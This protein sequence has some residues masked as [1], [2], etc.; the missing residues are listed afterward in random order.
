VKKDIPELRSMRPEP[1]RDFKTGKYLLPHP[2]EPGVVGAWDRATT[3]AGLHEDHAPLEKWQLRQALDG[4]TRD[5][6]ILTEVRGL[7][8]QAEA[9]DNWRDANA[10]KKK[11]DA[12]AVRA[13]DTAGSYDGSTWGTLLHT[14]TEW[15]DA[16]RLD[17]VL[18]EITSWG[19]KGE[20]LLRDLDVYTKTMAE[21][22]L[23]CPPEYIERI[24][25]NLPCSSG[26]T[27]DRMI[28]LPDGRLVIGDLK[29]QKD[30]D[31]GCLK[32]AAQLA[33][34]AFASGLLSEDGRSIEPMPADLD[35]TMAIIMHLP[36]G[37]AECR[38][39]QLTPEDMELGWALAQHAAAT[40]WYRSISRRVTGRPY[41][42]T[43]VITPDG[44]LSEITCAESR[45]HLESIWK[46]P[47][48]KRVWTDAHTAAAKVRSAELARLPK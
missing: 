36:V 5:P 20:M 32:I 39:I 33:E 7:V 38:L 40:M 19:P 11:L 47:T 13:L 35:P 46:R 15:A 18:P 16:G 23:V 12:L 26:G 45:G 48:V 42:P 28:R 37:K 9:A 8:E 14:I 10:P 43:S 30:M 34:Y 25:V 44:L 41:D 1:K 29:T 2:T 21:N 22:G 6:E 3:L 31:F 17:E 27:M 24:M 4:V